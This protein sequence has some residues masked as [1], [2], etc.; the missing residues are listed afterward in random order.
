MRPSATKPKA[1]DPKQEEPPVSESPRARSRSSS[2]DDDPVVTGANLP[3]EVVI[4]NAA[5]LID[6]HCEPLPEPDQTVPPGSDTESDDDVEYMK[7][8]GYT[9]SDTVEVVD[10]PEPAPQTVNSEAL[11]VLGSPRDV[12]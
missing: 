11:W 9:A 1:S 12:E 5:G 6:Q 7:A 10:S 3:T 4:V 8:L 2:S